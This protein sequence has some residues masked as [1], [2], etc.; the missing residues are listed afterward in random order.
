[1]ALL[2]RSNCIVCHLGSSL[3]AER[4]LQKDSDS[5]VVSNLSNIIVTS[6]L[7]T[8]S[9]ILFFINKTFMY[10]CLTCIMISLPRYVYCV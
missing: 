9:K 1:M 2:L 10:Y 6:L 3:L 7:W 5:N 8:L 4:I